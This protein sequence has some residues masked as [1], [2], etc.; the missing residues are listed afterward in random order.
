[1]KNMMK[2]FILALVGLNL[3]VPFFVLKLTYFDLEAKRKSYQ[4]QLEDIKRKNASISALL[5]KPEAV[6]KLQAEL[7]EEIEV[8]RKLM[9]PETEMI[10]AQKFLS[11]FAR[12]AGIVIVALRPIED[13]VPLILGGKVDAAAKAPNTATESSSGVQY[14]R[15]ELKVNGDYDDIC[16]YV[17]T[18][19]EC[20]D[21]TMA[22]NKLAMKQFTDD[23]GNHIEADIGVKIYY[24]VMS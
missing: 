5:N 12:E 3:I 1:M 7:N 17:S 15:V 16:K 23:Q 6:T 11:Q 24:S 13:S 9:P 4:K 8:L 21:V 22:V 20:A 19:E 2:I 10:A 14:A 18:I